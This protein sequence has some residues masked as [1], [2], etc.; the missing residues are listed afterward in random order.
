MK[1]YLTGEREK[2]NPAHIMYVAPAADKRNA[3]TNIPSDW[4]DDEKKPRTFPITFVHGRADVPDQLGNYLVKTGQAAASSL[5]R[6]NGRSVLGALADRVSPQ[7]T[8]F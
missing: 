7:R 5:L 2:A 3:P 8:Q 4:L 6:P 1:I